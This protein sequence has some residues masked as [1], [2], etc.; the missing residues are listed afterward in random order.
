MEKQ[1]RKHGNEPSPRAADLE[2]L[3]LSFRP[4]QPRA[5]ADTTT[6]STQPNGSG[7]D[8]F[9]SFLLKPGSSLHPAFLLALDVSC[10]LLF[11]IFGAGLYYTDGSIH[12]AV[13]FFVN[14]CLWL[15]IKW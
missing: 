5:M 6:S 11:V 8:G 3:Y 1:T 7:G 12:F 10:V 13:L 2:L 9:I 4:R 14:G 15:S